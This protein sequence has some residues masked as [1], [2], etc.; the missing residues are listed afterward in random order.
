[1]SNIRFPP[2]RRQGPKGEPGS[3]GPMGMKGND[4]PQGLPGL[5]GPPGPKGSTGETGP[6][7]DLGPS[8]P[9]GPP[10]P[11]GELPLVPPELLF[12]RYSP[13]SGR[14]KRELGETGHLDDESDLD[15]FER[16]KRAV[17]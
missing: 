2:C 12:Q 17:R 7:G 15:E 11:P 1:M 3:L 10:G 6:K 13:A 16:S 8:G 5:E 4:G 9:P 14:R